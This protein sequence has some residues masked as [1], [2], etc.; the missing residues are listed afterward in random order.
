M[1]ASSKPSYSVL[2]VTRSVG[3]GRKQEITTGDTLLVTDTFEDALGAVRRM[4]GRVV[5]RRDADNVVLA[6]RLKDPSTHSPS[7]T[8]NLGDFSL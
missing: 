1:K 5:I 6:T 3:Y 2:R 4:G 7:K 8:K